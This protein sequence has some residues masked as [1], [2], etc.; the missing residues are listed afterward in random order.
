MAGKWGRLSAWT[1]YCN[2]ALF[3]RLFVERARV[4]ESDYS[5]LLEWL[6]QRK[7]ALVN[8]SGLENP[9]AVA[10]AGEWLGGAAM[11]EPDSVTGA[12]AHAED[13][14]PWD[15]RVEANEDGIRAIWTRC[16]LAKLSC[17]CVGMAL[18][19]CNDEHFVE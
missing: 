4:K 10:A 16:F 13:M 17:G 5:V 12:L 18:G 11:E 3:L 9:A 19:P 14:A 6:M 8:L 15:G 1:R 2:S 7:F